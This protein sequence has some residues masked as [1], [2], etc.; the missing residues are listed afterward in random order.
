MSIGYDTRIYEGLI[1]E[2]K[3]SRDPKPEDYLQ[4]EL[5]LL[6]VLSR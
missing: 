2:A 6:T 1:K 3:D 5:Q 4:G